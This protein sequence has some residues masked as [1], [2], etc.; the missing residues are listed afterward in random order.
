L[1]NRKFDFEIK[2]ET[3]NEK[4]LKN[5]TVHGQH[6]DEMELDILE[7]PYGLS[8]QRMPPVHGWRLNKLE[9][10]SG[11]EEPYASFSFRA[12]YGKQE[13]QR[14]DDYNT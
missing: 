7:H 3:E 8:C 1:K 10:C 14:E 13:N 2:K 5:K 9:M 6:A 11:K 12:H 4:L